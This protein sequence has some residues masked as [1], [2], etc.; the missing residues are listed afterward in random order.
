VADWL[1]TP[2]EPWA[3]GTRLARFRGAHPDVEVMPGPGFWQADYRAR[4]GRKAFKARYELPVLLDDLEEE[5]RDELPGAVVVVSGRCDGACHLISAVV[6]DMS[7]ADEEELTALQAAVGDLLDR[8]EGRMGGDLVTALCR[9]REAAA[10]TL[11]QR[12]A[13][14]TVTELSAKRAG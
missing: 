7:K 14:A 4:D 13:Q 10:R 2:G 9:W 8:F 12:T 3:G 6:R 11:K 5:L 1:D